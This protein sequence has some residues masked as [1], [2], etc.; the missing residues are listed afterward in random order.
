MGDLLKEASGLAEYM[1][2]CRGKLHRCPECGFDLPET[3]AFVESELRSMGL[4]PH[5]CGR[6]GLTALVGEGKGGKCFLLRADMDALPDGRGGAFHGCGH[7]LHT[8]ML[9]GAAKLLKGREGELHAPV[10]LMFQPAEETLDG[11]KDMLD[12]GV[13]RCPDVGG[14]MMLHVMTAVPLPA[15]RIVIPTPGAS[16]PGADYFSI[17]VRGRGCHGSSPNTGVDPINAA[18]HIVIALQEISTREL[19]MAEQAVL[20]LGSVHGGSAGNVIPNVVTMSGTVRAVAEETRE[21]VKRRLC[22]VSSGIAAS[23]RAEAEVCFGSGCPC[24]WNDGDL[25]SFAGKTL[26]GALGEKCCVSAADFPAAGGRSGR[27]AGSEDFS[28]I[29]RKV[30]SVMLAIAAGEPAKGFDKPLHHPAAR[31][32]ENAMPYGTAALAACALN[33]GN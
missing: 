16:A 26:R 25:L 15:G 24:L 33:W 28:Y 17:F 7:D 21:Y 1:S 14:A 2:F 20:T 23:F 5:R 30:P 18:A 19:G 8:A 9:L 22:E 27:T 31:F 4:E 6:S 13:L 3:L 29:S 12:D 32:D 11:A 10:K